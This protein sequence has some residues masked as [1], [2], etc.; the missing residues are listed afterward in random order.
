MAKASIFIPSNVYTPNTRSVILPNLTSDDNGVKVILTREAWPDTGDVIVSGVIE[1]SNDNWATS[2]NLTSFAYA[3]GVM[4]NPR[5]LLPVLTVEPTA[6]WPETYDPVT[7]VATP[8]RP[9]QVRMVV[10]NTVTI[11]T[12]IT[13]TGV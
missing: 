3:G 12:S 8:L 5:T 4:I 11:T 7:G 6:Y 9:A 1:G 2:F 13:L 10:T